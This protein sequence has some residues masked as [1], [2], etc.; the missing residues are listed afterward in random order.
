MNTKLAHCDTSGPENSCC[1]DQRL[2]GTM[3]PAATEH[4]L[5]EQAIHAFHNET[6]LL[7]HVIQEQVKIDGL[8]IDAIIKSPHD[9]DKFAVEVKRWAPQ[10]NLGALADQVKRLPMEGV[11]VADY[12]NPNMGKKLKE[13]NVQYFDTVGNAY[14]KQ[15][16]LYIHVTGKKQREAQTVAKKATNRAFD[17]TGL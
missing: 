3:D 16:S 14:I 5:L 9:G 6:G 13:M 17:A 11:L 1:I 15:P 8:I 2:S 7:M 4:Q 12:I 10:A